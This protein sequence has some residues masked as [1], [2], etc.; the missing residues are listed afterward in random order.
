MIAITY[1]LIFFPLRI[2]FGLSLYNSGVAFIALA[3]II[4]DIIVSL[5]TGFY[6]R[7]SLVSDRVGILMNYLTNRALTDSLSVLPFLIYDISG[8]NQ[9]IFA[10]PMKLIE[11]AISVLFLTRIF[12]LG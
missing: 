11:S 9:N 3:V 7:G 1:F 6:D 2:A 12:H 10:D 4:L 8:V 5:N